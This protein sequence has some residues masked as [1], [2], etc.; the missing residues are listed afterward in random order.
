MAIDYVNKRGDKSADNYT[1]F[2][3][4]TNPNLKVIFLDQLVTLSSSVTPKIMRKIDEDLKITGNR[5]PELGQRWYPLSIKIN[6]QD[7]FPKAK[8]FTQSIGR[9]KYILPVYQALVRNGMRSLAYQWFDERKNFY[10][11]LTAK[12]IR[13][14]IFSSK[15]KEL[16]VEEILRVGV[17]IQK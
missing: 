6:Y 1:A 4:T 16:T 10:H 7:A 8:N 9:Q 17:K 3:E 12:K 13:A 14:I 15:G 2:L 11:P 5:N